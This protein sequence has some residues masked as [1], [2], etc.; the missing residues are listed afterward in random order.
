METALPHGPNGYILSYGASYKS[1]SND[2][3]WNK[4]P[5]CPPSA[6][7]IHDAFVSECGFS[8]T[9]PAN[10]MKMSLAGA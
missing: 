6:T 4:V 5:Q 2:N 9:F 8:S 7:A 10:W 1:A 3:A